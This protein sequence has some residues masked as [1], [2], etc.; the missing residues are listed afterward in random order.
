[1]IESR[2]VYLELIYS[3]VLIDSCS[4][5]AVRAASRFKFYSLNSFF[6]SLSFYFKI[7]KF[8]SNYVDYSTREALVSLEDCRDA[9]S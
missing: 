8:V 4:N 2:V 1:V 7:T 3:S 5:T 6:K 9:L